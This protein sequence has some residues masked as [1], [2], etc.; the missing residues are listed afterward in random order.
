MEDISIALGAREAPGTIQPNA[1]TSLINRSTLNFQMSSPV[2]RSS[3]PKRGQRTIT[4]YSGRRQRRSAGVSSRITNPELT[5]RAAAQKWTKVFRNPKSL[6]GE[7]Y[8][9]SSPT[10]S[11]VVPMWVKVSELTEEEK[12]KYEEVEKKKEE[13]RLAWRNAMEERRAS[14]VDAKEDADE[15]DMNDDSSDEDDDRN[16]SNNS[17]AGGV[18]DEPVVE[19]P[20][21]D[22]SMSVEESS[23]QNEMDDAVNAKEVAIEEVAASNQTSDDMTEPPST[24]GGE[25]SVVDNSMKSD[26]VTTAQ[27]NNQK[28]EDSAQVEDDTQSELLLKKQRLDETLDAQEFAE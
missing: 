5:S 4:S 7:P 2:G 27:S 14:E 19:N 12:L 9:G 8:F 23:N 11:F 18:Q 28:E 1:F 24:H 17:K 25:S 13:E 16:E 3:Y 21:A 20:S 26:V 10:A 6:V 22:I 15:N